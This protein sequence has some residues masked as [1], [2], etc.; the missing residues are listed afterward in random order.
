LKLSEAE[1]DHYLRSQRIHQNNMEFMSFFLPVF[2]VA[3]VYNPLHTALAGTW[4]L[5]FRML[6]AFGYAKSSS[7]RLVGA[8]FHFGEL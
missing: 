6:Y 1:V 4:V 2:V 3:G 5:V 7:A 8:P